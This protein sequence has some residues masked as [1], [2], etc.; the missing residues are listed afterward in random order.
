MWSENR[1]TK[2]RKTLIAFAV[3]VFFYATN[4]ATRHGRYS[5]YA[6]FS[7][8]S[9]GI[10][11]QSVRDLLPGVSAFHNQSIKIPCKNSFLFGVRHG[12]SPFIIVY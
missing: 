3:G 11:S 4:F 1:N 12:S 2:Q 9:I 8:F 7:V 6:V 10:E 5:I